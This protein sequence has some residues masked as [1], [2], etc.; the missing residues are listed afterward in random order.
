MGGMKAYQ[1][2][3]E[4]MTDAL[5]YVVLALGLIGFFVLVVWG[6]TIMDLTG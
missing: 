2:R 3:R 4:T 6:A 5:A 1:G